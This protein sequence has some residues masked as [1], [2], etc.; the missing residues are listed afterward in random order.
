M[1]TAP[2]GE[3]SS[4]LRMFLVRVI[5]MQAKLGRLGEQYMDREESE[6]LEKWKHWR[7][8]N[9]RIEMNFE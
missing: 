2:K 6:R 4:A 8:N 9:H 1:P 7:W 5:V 3:L